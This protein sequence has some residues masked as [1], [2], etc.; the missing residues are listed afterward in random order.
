MLRRIDKADFIVKT[1]IMDTL[2]TCLSPMAC[3]DKGLS[4]LCELNYSVSS[5]LVAQNPCLRFMWHNLTECATKTSVLCK[6]DAMSLGQFY[7]WSSR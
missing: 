1:V 7:L 3:G 5:I 2:G 6:T 4:Y